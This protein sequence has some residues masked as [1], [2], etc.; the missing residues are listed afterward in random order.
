VVRIQPPPPHRPI[1]PTHV[2]LPAGTQLLRIYDPLYLGPADYKHNGPRARF[3]HHEPVSPA[4]DDL[5]HGVYYAAPTLA[6]CIV[7]VFGD[8]GIIKTERFR[9][10]LVE[11][12]RA[13]KL[14]QLRGSGAWDAGASAAVAKDSGRALTQAWA[15]F[16]YADPRYGTVDGL[17]YGNAHNDMQAYALF[18]RAGA[19]TVVDD[20]PL[21]EPRLEA[22]LDEIALDLGLVVDHVH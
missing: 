1:T 15:R 18:E 2:P 21:S 8:D 12:P 19:L 9:V 10:A 4:A 7:E 16:F 13:L 20:C 3:D 17:S 11:T 5:V 14:L 22:E 6:G